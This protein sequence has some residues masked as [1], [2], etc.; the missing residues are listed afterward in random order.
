MCETF[1]S[2]SEKMVMN[3]HLEKIVSTLVGSIR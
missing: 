1:S 3:V 2:K